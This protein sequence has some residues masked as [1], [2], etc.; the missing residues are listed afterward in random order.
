[1]SHS[2]RDQELITALRRGR[3]RASYHLVKA[4]IEG[5]KAVEAV[6]DELARLRRGEPEEP[7]RIDIEVE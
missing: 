1:M 7:P 5:L 4:A 3:R 6:L 2:H